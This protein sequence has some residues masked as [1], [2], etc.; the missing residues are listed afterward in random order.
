MM[1]HIFVAPWVQ[2]RRIALLQDA[3]RGSSYV[4][5]NVDV[6]GALF[7][8]SLE[9]AEGE[10]AVGLG[11]R[12][13]DADVDNASEQLYEIEWFTRKN[14]KNDW[15]LRPAFKLKLAGYRKEGRRSVPYWQTS[16]EP[17]ASF[18]PIVVKTSGSAADEPVLTQDCMSALRAYMKSR[19]A[20]AGEAEA[21]EELDGQV[22][23]SEK[24]KRKRKA[25]KVVDDDE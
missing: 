20:E 22:N 19:A 1:I 9:H 5:E 8:F 13:F 11:R 21:D 6:K 18:L 2:D 24:A 4:S 7:L 16:V 25:N 23:V 3:K 10:F 15:G 12:T 14:K 17:I